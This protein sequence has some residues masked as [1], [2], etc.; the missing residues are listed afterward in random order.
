MVVAFPRDRLSATRLHPVNDALAR[1]LQAI[2]QIALGF[3]ARVVAVFVPFVALD[4]IALQANVR[5]TFGRLRY[6]FASPTFHRWH[7]RE[8]DV[9]PEEKVGPLATNVAGLFP[10]W[11]LLFGT[12]SV[13][14]DRQPNRPALP[15]PSSK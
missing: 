8:M 14:R 9:G 11:D 1:G 5:W 7:T 15:I 10:I 2:P 12:F 4:A 13:P 6:V 3:D